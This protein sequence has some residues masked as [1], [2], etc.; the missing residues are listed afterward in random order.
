MVFVVAQ[1]VLLLLTVGFCSA[2]KH[3]VHTSTVRNYYDTSLQSVPKPVPFF[4][5]REP[6][7]SHCPFHTKNE[8]FS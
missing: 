6:P 1:T 7:P 3:F 8:S 5:S 4:L 2:L